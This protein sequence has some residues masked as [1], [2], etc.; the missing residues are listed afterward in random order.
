MIGEL[1]GV[2]NPLPLTWL[3]S[4]FESLLLLPF[5]V[6]GSE[7]ASA[8]GQLDSR[9]NPRFVGALNLVLVL[10]LS[11]LLHGCLH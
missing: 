2:Q 6:T 7:S 4:V 10:F 3:K 11:Y 8:L 1:T 9:G 5:S